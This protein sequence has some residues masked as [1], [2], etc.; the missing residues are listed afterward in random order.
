MWYIL[1]ALLS[2]DTGCSAVFLYF[3]ISDY[4]GKINMDELFNYIRKFGILNAEEELLIAEGLQEITIEKGE[5]FIEAGKVSR[6]I[7]FVKEG[8]FRSLY[9]NKLGDDFTRYFIYEG[10]F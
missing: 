3:Y 6:K 9:Y 7:A 5:A 2:N 10:R 4:S 8:V 1:Y